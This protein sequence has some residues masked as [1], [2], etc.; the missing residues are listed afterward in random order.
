[1][2]LV[3]SVLLALAVGLGAFIWTTSLTRVFDA[4]WVEVAAVLRKPQRVLTEANIAVLHDF[5]QGGARMTVRLA[6]IRY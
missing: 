6:G 2:I 3:L 1:M 5:S 4:R